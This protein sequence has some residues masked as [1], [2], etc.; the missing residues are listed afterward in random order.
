VLLSGLTFS[1]V[2]AIFSPSRSTGLTLVVL[3]AMG[4]LLLIVFPTLVSAV[5]QLATPGGLR[6]RVMSVYTLAWQGLEYVGVL[7]TGTLATMWGA[8]AA[9]LALPWSWRLCC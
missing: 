6:G 7:L 8:S 3:F 1:V 5:L 2:L 9:V 4:L